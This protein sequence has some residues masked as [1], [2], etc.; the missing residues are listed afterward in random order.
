MKISRP[1]SNEHIH[2]NTLSL[3]VATDF[4]MRGKFVGIVPCAK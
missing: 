3:G 4:N 1:V 2:K